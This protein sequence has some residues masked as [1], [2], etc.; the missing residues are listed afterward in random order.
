MS[1]PTIFFVAP[2]GEALTM[3]LPATFDDMPNV[4][5]KNITPGIV[6]D[7]DFALTGERTREPTYFREEDNH[8]IYKLDDEL[9][10]ALAELI[11]EDMPEVADEWGIFDISDTM[12]FLAELRS[13]A[14]ESQ[15][16]DEGVFLYW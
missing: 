1:T 3:E 14:K 13:L 12:E 6:G 15:A 7:L 10:I 11:D 8:V 16:R 5:S 4:R 9:V 2:A